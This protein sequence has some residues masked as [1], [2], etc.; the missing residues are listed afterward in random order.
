M[1]QEIRYDFLIPGIK[2]KIKD[3]PNSQTYQS[4]I[5]KEH[6]GDGKCLQYFENENVYFYKHYYV[7]VPQKEKIQQA[8]EQRALSLILKRIVNEDFTW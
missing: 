4:G 7:L 3:L 1:F 5:F 6:I 8:M 2:Y